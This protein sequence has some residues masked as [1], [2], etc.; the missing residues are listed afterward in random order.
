[1]LFLAILLETTTAA[2][3]YTTE[4]ILSTTTTVL[5]TETY[6]PTS[7]YRVTGT[8]GT[9]MSTVTDGEPVEG[10][11]ATTSL[12]PLTTEAD[13]IDPSTVD[14]ITGTDSNITEEAVTVVDTD[15]TSPATMVSVTTPDRNETTPLRDVTT[16]LTDVTTP[17]RDVTTPLTG[18]T[19]V[20]GNLTTP[21]NDVTTPAGH[22]TTPIVDVTTP[23]DIST[24]PYVPGVCQYDGDSM[25]IILDKTSA[26]ITIS[27][28]VTE[29]TDSVR[30]EHRLESASDWI[31]SE[32]L[33]PAR[34]TQ[35]TITNL[36]VDSLYNIRLRA[37]EVGREFDD[38]EINE[39][40][41]C[42]EGLEG[43]DCTTETPTETPTDEPKT[44]TTESPAGTSTTTDYI[45]TTQHLLPTATAGPRVCFNT[46]TDL[47][48]V[49]ES[50][51]DTEIHI[52]WEFGFSSDEFSVEYRPV[53]GTWIVRENAN[54]NQPFFKIKQLEPNTNYEI[55]IRAVVYDV[56]GG[57]YCDT[58]FQMTCPDGT[59]GFDCTG[60]VPGDDD[61][62]SVNVTVGSVNSVSI[63]STWIASE[64]VT[65]VVHQYRV[66]GSI[67]WTD[68][69][70]IPIER[71]MYFLTDLQPDSLYEV[72]LQFETVE[73]VFYTEPETTTTCEAGFAGT[74]TCDTYYRNVSA[75]DVSLSFTQ[76]DSMVLEWSIEVDYAQ[77]VIEYR[78]AESETD[79]FSS[80]PFPFPQQSGSVEGLDPN[81]NYELRVRTEFDNSG[82]RRRRQSED[83][84]CDGCAYSATVTY[85]SCSE[86]FEGLNCQDEV[87]V[88]PSSPEWWLILTMVVIATLLLLLILIPLVVWLKN[89]WSKEEDKSKYEMGMT[90]TS[91]Q[92]SSRRVSY[93]QADGV[94]VQTDPLPATNSN[95]VYSTEAVMYFDSESLH[96]VNTRSTLG[97][98]NRAMSLDG[99]TPPSHVDSGFSVDGSTRSRTIQ[100]SIENMMI[101]I[102]GDTDSLAQ[103]DTVINI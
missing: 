19:T 93:D 79:W 32:S 65:S 49:V 58:V 53:N 48:L 78:T 22:V 14:V 67:D 64:G 28:I 3:N 90:M 66:L 26:T 72:R 34:E 62:V 76:S 30:V 102:E 70:P 96:S 55:L 84:S 59:E 18:V 1:M 21:V 80:E 86:G 98:D 69:E 71:T 52:K 94:G 42:E 15:G 50:V 57:D 47:S 68:S 81:Q 45:S 63:S 31:L 20:V 10:S 12:L 37:I 36:Q 95:Y 40:R 16:P 101:P 88:E 25:I 75:F 23:I 35:Y 56:A 74:S 82:L 29:T 2:D 13:V 85:L 8:E 44:T 77:N 99:E 11:T 60:E 17:L 87:E 73:G 4:N 6:Q 33:Q 61:L 46:S 89:N 83:E 103:S 24:T 27:W 43:V 38:C 92:G 100:G 91:V 39:E 41:T 97:H 7:P 5:E 54:Q 9:V 51:K